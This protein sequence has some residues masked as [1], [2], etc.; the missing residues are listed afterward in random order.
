[1][2]L[3][4]ERQMTGSAPGQHRARVH[5]DARRDHERGV[6][7]DAELPDDLEPG[8]LVL[9]RLGVGFEELE[10]TRAGDGAEVLDDLVA[11]HPDAVVFD[12]DG[13]RVVV[14]LDG[15]AG[16]AR[17][18]PVRRSGSGPRKR[19]L[20]SASDALE[21]SSRRKTSLCV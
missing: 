1:M 18:A 3:P 2:P 19:A 17:P 14:E 11:G 15:D 6:E 4:V 10:R 7:T 13:A 9:G 12:G 20:S 16:F 8:V 5:V 21:M